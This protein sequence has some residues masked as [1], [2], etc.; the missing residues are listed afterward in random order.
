M[1]KKGLSLHA[2]S[3]S[4]GM[5]TFNKTRGL[6][7]FMNV[8]NT[9]YVMKNGTK[10]EFVNAMEA[11][12]YPIWSTMYHP[13]YQLLDFV[14]PQRWLLPDRKYTEEIAFRMSLLLNRTARKN[15]NRVAKENS[16]I[17][18]DAMAIDR[19]PEQPFM[20]IGNVHILAYGFI[21]HN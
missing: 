8:L 14:G 11:K 3:F 9:D 18:N 20:L 12:S 10:V 17:F 4:I 21:Q 13:E 16:M 15:K 1:E 7:E 6:H 2:H 5:D 19:V